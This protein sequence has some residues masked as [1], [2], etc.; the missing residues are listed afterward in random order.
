MKCG[1][2]QNSAKQQ[3]KAENH[4]FGPLRAFGYTILK[5]MNI[6]F[7]A[8]W[9]KKFAFKEWLQYH[10][11][12][13]HSL[14]K[15]VYQMSCLWLMAPPVSCIY[16][17]ASYGYHKVLISVISADG[18]AYRLVQ[19]PTE[20]FQTH[21]IVTANQPSQVCCQ[22]SSFWQESF[23]SFLI[24]ALD[25]HSK[26]WGSTTAYVKYHICNIRPTASAPFQWSA[27]QSTGPKW[28]E[29]RF[30]V[31]FHRRSKGFQVNF[32]WWWAQV[33]CCKHQINRLHFSQPHSS[34]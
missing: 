31:N 11:K 4:N 13:L 3:S 18:V 30:S 28:L 25:S 10:N 22:T 17:S 21:Q 6:N 1:H 24:D 27:G 29:I 7:F 33:S 12:K 9:C 19:F 8:I 32:T 2:L 5:L 14:L 16:Y 20:T 34:P 23:Q 26:R 15:F